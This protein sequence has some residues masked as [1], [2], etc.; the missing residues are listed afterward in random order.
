MYRNEKRAVIDGPFRIPAPEYRRPTTVK[1]NLS[2][3]ASRR[4]PEAGEVE[5]FPGEGKL[6][7]ICMLQAPQAQIRISTLFPQGMVGP[8]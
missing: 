7:I 3:S 4:P 1:F 8:P 2:F 6:H 5:Q